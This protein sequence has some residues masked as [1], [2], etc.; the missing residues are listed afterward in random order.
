M[1]KSMTGFGKAECQLPDEKI[2]I[3]IKTLNSKQFDILSRVHGLYKQKELDIRAMLLKKLER[4]KIEITLTVDQSNTAANYSLNKGL[5]KK[6]FDEIKSLSDE[7]QLEFENDIIPSIL[8]LPDVLQAEDRELDETTWE[9]VQLSVMEA[10]NKCDEFRAIEGKNLEVDFINRIGLI[11][12]FLDQITPFEEE[13]ID[14]IKTKFRKDLSDVVGNKKIDENRFEQEIIYYLEKIDITEEKVRL[15]NNCEYFLQAMAE[16]QSNGKKLNFICQEIGREINTIG[17]KANDSE[18]Q[19][20]VVQMKDE[21]EKIKEQ[22][23]NIL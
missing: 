13:R 21:L 10:I 15:K 9:Q 18:I 20:L 6:Y 7:L 17:S 2:S 3:E 12:G 8:K 16:N 1:L 4:G 11:L 23:F 22:M 5:A 19:K 14:K